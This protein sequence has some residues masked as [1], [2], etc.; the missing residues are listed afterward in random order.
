ME[1]HMSHPLG[2]LSY[3]ARDPA[4]RRGF[5]A[6]CRRAIV[7]TVTAAVFVVIV[8]MRAALLSAG[9]ICVFTGLILL[10]LGGKVS[11]GRKLLEWRERFIDLSRLWLSDIAR[12]FRRRRRDVETPSPLPVVTVIPQ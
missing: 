7:W 2:I 5:F 4:R 3:A 1:R 12:P 10:T 9:F 8:T 11:A 6:T